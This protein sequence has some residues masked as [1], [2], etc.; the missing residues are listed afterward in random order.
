MSRETLHE[1]LRLR[2]CSDMK[3]VNKV[4]GGVRWRC[5]DA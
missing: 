2:C 5:V 1:K 3:L 4:C